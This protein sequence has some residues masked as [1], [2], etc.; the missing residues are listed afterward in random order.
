MAKKNRHLWTSARKNSGLPPL[1]ATD[2]S[3]PAWASL[4]YDLTCVVSANLRLNTLSMPP[5]DGD[6]PPQDCDRNRASFVDYYIRKRWCK[7]C[8]HGIAAPTRSHTLIYPV[9][10]DRQDRRVCRILA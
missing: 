1:T 10:S 4:L 7:D 3:D 8:K 2:F 9:P 6:G 5:A